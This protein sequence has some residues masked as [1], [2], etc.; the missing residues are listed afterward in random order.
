MDFSGKPHQV[1]IKLLFKAFGIYPAKAKK[2]EQLIADREN[3]LKLK[4]Q[5]ELLK[6]LP[7]NKF[8]FFANHFEHS[9]SQFYQDLFIA[10][11]LGGKKNGFFVEIG[12]CDGLRLSNSLFFERHMGWRG[13][14]AEPGK[15]WHPALKKNRLAKIDFRAVWRTSGCKMLFNE[16]ESREVSTLEM[17]NKA[18]FHSELR[19]RGKQYMVDTISLEDLL[20]AHSAPDEIDYL[21]IDTE[22]SEFDILSGFD[23]SKRLVRCITCEHNFTTNREKIHALLTSKGYIRKYCDF[24]ECDDWYF[25]LNF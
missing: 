17:F 23:F 8:S 18:D 4:L 7:E 22:G 25:L 16:T 9:A 6:K 24:S 11:E 14:L 2:Y 10:S 20:E 1:I 3:L 21:S 19:L 13:V 12:A 5:L 15:A